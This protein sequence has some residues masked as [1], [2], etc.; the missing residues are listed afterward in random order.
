MHNTSQITEL[1]HNAVIVI[2]KHIASPRI[3]RI[4]D[5][6]WGLRYLKYIFKACQND[7]S[8]DGCFIADMSINDWVDGE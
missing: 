5:N 6:E 4:E 3:K 8:P 1:H 2:V 7:T